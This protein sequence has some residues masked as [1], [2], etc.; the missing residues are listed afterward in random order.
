MLGWI[1]AIVL[2]VVVVVL[3]IRKPAPAA[4]PADRATPPPTER[5]VSSDEAM[6]E[7]ARY[8]QRAVIA[9]LGGAG[10]G[11]SRE[12]AA[13][14][15]VDALRDL[16]AYAAVTADPA[17]AEEN[18]LSVLQAVT[19]EY[20]AATG[21]PVRVRGPDR[22]VRVRVSTERFKDAVYMVLV[23]A[24]HFGGG[25]TVDIEV[26]EREGRA[27]VKVRD[28]GPGFTSEALMRAF[29]PFWTSED[30]A[31]GLGLPHARRLL[32]AQDGEISVGNAQGGGG[33]AVITVHK[34]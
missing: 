33:E 10:T 22:P 34:A 8:L 13:Q 14:D 4:R 29:K 16:V 6:R 18:L 20:T 26:V 17:D 24:G 27:D 15:A 28:K 11:E 12:R 30:D 9:P 21:V 25:G 32:E 7:M 19:R 1:V 23:N 5:E 31:L 3:L 2:A